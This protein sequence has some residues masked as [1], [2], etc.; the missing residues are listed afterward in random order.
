M[1]TNFLVL[2]ESVSLRI[3]NV[4]M[5]RIVMTEVMSQIAMVFFLLKLSVQIYLLFYLQINIINQ[6]LLL[7]F[8]QRQ[9]LSNKLAQLVRQCMVIIQLRMKHLQRAISI[10]VAKELPICIVM[11]MS[12]PKTITSAQPL[13]NQLHHQDASGK[14]EVL[15][16]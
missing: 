10:Q 13:P 5:R 15:T 2:M 8:Q 11:K 1:K 4:M 14:K 7:Q 9:I 12:L 3:S 6:L 16:L